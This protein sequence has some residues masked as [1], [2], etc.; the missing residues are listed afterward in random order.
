VNGA[1]REAAAEE[2]EP[3]GMN[4]ERLAEIAGFVLR[5]ARRHPVLASLTFVVVAALGITISAIMP[6]TYSATV[7]ILAQRVSAIRMIASPNP[8]IDDNPTKNVAAMITRR[9]NLLSLVKEANLVERNRATRSAALKLKDRVFSKL[10]GPASDEDMQLALAQT[11]EQRLEVATPDDTS[12]TI[13][14]DWSN[15][16]L[17][18]DLVTLVQK[19][20]LEARY[21]ADVAVV[22]ESIAVLEERAKAELA[23]VDTELEEYQKVMAERTPKSAANGSPRPRP[24]PS[25]GV[26]L[27]RAPSSVPEQDP[28]VAKQLEDIRVRIRALEG[29]QQK[30]ID[31][32]RQ[33]LTQ[34][35]LT[36][37]PIHPTVIALRQQ[38]ENVS[39]PTP[40]LTELRGQER[41]LMAQIAPPRP[42]PMATAPVAALRAPAPD[43]A[44]SASSDAPNAEP[45]PVFDDRDGVV[46]VAQSKLT[47]A[48]RSYEDATSRVDH[49]KMELDVTRA[50]YKYRYTVVTPAEVPKHPKK[51]TANIVAIGSVL[52]GVI[53]A[54]LL[55]AAADLA[56]GRVLEPWQVRRRLKVEILGELD[57]PS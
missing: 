35:E 21:D 52:G 48:I 43:P 26:Q 17:A 28:N 50:A 6:R 36:Y 45:P 51:A 57:I 47:S 12:L 40:E 1:E 54:L 25:L 10:L 53:L 22:T 46:Q 44:G 33:Q 15:P 3:E 2:A 16:Q 39:Q 5:A 4:L 7:K 18:Y 41:A 49:A 23:N 29:E 37:T 56:S 38:L 42:I 11:L 55:A 20:F 30:S 34:A 8:Q 24:R 32:A 13:T 14:V 9:D 19:N 27:P 31:E